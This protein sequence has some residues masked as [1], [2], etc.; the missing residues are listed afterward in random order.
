M[1]IYLSLLPLMVHRG[2]GIRAAVP[3]DTSLLHGD[4]ASPTQTLP[5]A[6][7][8]PPSGGSGT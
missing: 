2:G 1:L 4:R 7:G 6:D 3:S 8:C 5:T